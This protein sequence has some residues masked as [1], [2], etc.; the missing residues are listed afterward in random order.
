MIEEV[1]I[2]VIYK[3]QGGI[4]GMVL[5]DFR[6]ISFHWFCPGI[7]QQYKK[8]RLGLGTLPVLLVIL[9]ADFGDTGFLG[10]S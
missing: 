3:T 10:G 2:M 6:F 9:V 1:Y 4:N 5:L 7:S 8:S